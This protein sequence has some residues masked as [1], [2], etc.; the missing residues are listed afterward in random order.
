LE[1]DPI[2][3][4]EVEAV[5]LVKPV[6]LASIVSVVK[7][8]MD[9]IFL[10]CFLLK[11]APMAGLPVA[12]EDLHK[13]TYQDLAAPV[14]EEMEPVVVPEELD[15]QALVGVAVVPL[16]SLGVVAQTPLVALEAAGW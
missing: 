11:W 8:V 7:E 15:C 4:L 1:E 14:E 12:E 9:W 13:V 3:V 6:P 5:V 10:L 16:P 2:S